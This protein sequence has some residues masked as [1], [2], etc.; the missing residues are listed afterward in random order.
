MVAVQVEVVLLAFLM[1]V[2]IPWTVSMELAHTHFDRQD[3]AVT[4]LLILA[5]SSSLRE[6]LMVMVDPR[7]VNL[8]TTS[9]VCSP[10]EMF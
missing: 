4:A 8:S 9:R 7:Y 2:E 3:N 5:F 10:I 1:G 6:R